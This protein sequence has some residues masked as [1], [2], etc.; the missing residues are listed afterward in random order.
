MIDVHAID[1]QKNM[2]TLYKE[3][4]KCMKERLT[5]CL[6]LL[7]IDHDNQISK[8]AFDLIEKTVSDQEKK[9]QYGEWITALNAVAGSCVLNQQILSQS[10]IY[11]F[12]TVAVA[13]NIEEKRRT[14]A[15]D[16]V[17]FKIYTDIMTNYQSSD[18]RLKIEYPK[19]V[20][21]AIAILASGVDA[22]GKKIL[23]HNIEGYYQMRKLDASDAAS[24]SR[25]IATPAKKT[26]TTSATAASIATLAN[27]RKMEE[28]QSTP[29]P[30]LS[31]SKMSQDANK[32]QQGY[33]G[34]DILDSLNKITNRSKRDLEG[35]ISKLQKT[36]IIRIRDL[37]RNYDK[38][39]KYTKLIATKGNSLEQQQKFKIALEKDI[40]REL[41][42]FQLQH[43]ANSI[44]KAK[45][46]IENVLDRKF[47]PHGSYGINHTKHNLEYG[48]LIVGLMHSSR[49][50][51]ALKTTKDGS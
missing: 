18:P 22:G 34:R 30:P 49:K 47:V 4:L 12:L 6:Q 9:T 2:P 40:G 50:R 16:D 39:Q 44:R 35:S 1:G 28:L 45:L 41:S 46:Y 14:K 31:G 15:I 33:R 51:V 11:D 38:L 32:L 42:E 27:R 7:K 20:V 25:T 10:E 29:L 17:I 21:D 48:Y 43:A 13:T 37:C 8:T 19:I 26:T 24:T 5:R 36:D 23:V 3:K